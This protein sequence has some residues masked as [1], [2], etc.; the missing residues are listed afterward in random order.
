MKSPQTNHAYPEA[1]SALDMRH[2]VQILADRTWLPLLVLVIAIGAAD[3]YLYVTPKTYSSTGVLYVEQRDQKVVSVDDVNQ[4]DLESTDMMKTVEQSL[5]TPDILFRVISENHLADNPDFLD[6]RALPYTDDELLKAL[7]DRL[8]VKVRRGTRLI[9]VIAASHNPVLSQHIVQSLMSD[10]QQQNLDQRTA[11]AAAA[12]DFLFQQ[13]DKLK[14]KLEK[15]EK[16]LETYR[17]QNNAVSLEEKQNIVVDTLKDLNLKLG[18]ARSLRMKLEAD[19]ASYQ[20]A[21][22]DPEKLRLL[23]SVATDP[24]VLDAQNRVADQQKLIAGLAQEYRPEHP[25]YIDAQ[26]QLAQLQTALNDVILKSAAQI[27]TNYN[28]AAANEQKIEQALKDQEQQAMQLDKIAIPYNVLGRT[29]VADR[30]LFQSTVT[31]WKE[32]DLT[33]A[34]DLTPV[35]VISAPRVSQEP[36]GPKALMILAL[37]GFVGLFG[38]VGLTVFISS[39]DA[40]MRSA[41]EAEAALE[42]HVLASV[43]RCRR[44]STNQGLPILTHP[45]SAAAEAFRSLRTVLELKEVTDRQLIVF[46]SSS[47]GEGK[48]FCSIN[49]AV[50][51]AQQ[52]YRTLIV[53]TD[54]RHPSV[55]K[56]LGISPGQPGL[57]DCL[58]GRMTANDVVVGTTISEL[59]VLTAG[60]SVANCAELMSEKRLADL[61]SDTVFFSHFERIIFDTAPVNAVSDALHLVKHATSICLVVQAGRTTVNA[62][63]RAHTALTS[64]RASDIGIVLNRVSPS[65]Y[66]PYGYSFRDS[67]PPL[68]T[69]RV[70]TFSR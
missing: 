28:A 37:A 48:T 3:V 19:M 46:T 69:G 24:A 58:A 38:G 21:G 22:S 23:S 45:E 16:E 6:K 41:D 27:S 4:Q 17:E 65:R 29:M 13:V 44:S 60:S 54:L 62:A 57:G 35:R 68:V 64:A 7:T 63:K 55:G 15:S 61:L 20:Q 39:L 31:R 40:S 70:T 47:A 43:P 51:L 18:D 67:A 53:D 25:K 1:S 5:T 50:A 36:T 30:D 52:G 33:R 10:Y 8:K 14:T 59:F 34:L 56:R 11:T 32:T 9:D 42:L 2:L 26:A 66:N 49:C 12:N